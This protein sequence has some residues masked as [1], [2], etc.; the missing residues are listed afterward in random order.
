[1]RGAQPTH[2][3]LCHKA[4]HTNLRYPVS[5]VAIPP[6]K[7]FIA[8]N[9]AVAN[10]CGSLQKAK[11]VGVALNTTGLKEA[12]A[13]NKINSIKTNTGLPV[14]DVVRFGTDAL[15]DAIETAMHA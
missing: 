4:A 5:H 8:L 2:L 1:M 15:V 12:E 7:E 13:L 9:E 14:T 3:I 10:V 6:L 11:C